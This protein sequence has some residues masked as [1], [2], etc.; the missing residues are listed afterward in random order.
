[1]VTILTI[2]EETRTGRRGLLTGTIVGAVSACVGGALLALWVQQRVAPRILRVPPIPF[3][4]DLAAWDRISAMTI[5]QLVCAVSLLVAGAAVLGRRRIAPPVFALLGWGGLFFTIAA[6][7]PG[8][9]LRFKMQTALNAAQRLGVVGP[10][11]TFWD[12]VPG[13]YVAWGVLLAAA[14]LGL[15]I[16]GTV[17]LVRARDA[18]D[19]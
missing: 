13:K 18:Y 7:W 2:V 4:D 15:L 19:R 14:W 12:L 16:A 10:R 9:T 5:T 11:A 17:H 8:D 6:A 3:F 1:M